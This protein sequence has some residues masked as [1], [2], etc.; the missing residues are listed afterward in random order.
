MPG[1]RAGQRATG[2]GA[3]TPHSARD[4]NKQVA[5]IIEIHL[6]D[7]SLEKFAAVRHERPSVAAIGRLIDAHASFGITRGVGFTG[8]RVDSL[9]GGIARI[10][11]Q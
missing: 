5:C 4:R 11:K 10:K 3:D 9:A 8:T 1:G 2:H 6:P 7:R